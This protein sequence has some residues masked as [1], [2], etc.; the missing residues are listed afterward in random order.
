MYIIW[1][2]PVAIVTRI[3]NDAM[4]PPSVGMAYCFGGI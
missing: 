4:Q 2:S 3:T 1:P